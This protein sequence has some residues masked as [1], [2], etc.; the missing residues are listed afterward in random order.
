VPSRDGPGDSG[1]R[2][3]GLGRA[4]R[5]SSA[6]QWF[7]FP[8]PA[9][10]GGGVALTRSPPVQTRAAC[11]DL[12]LEPSLLQVLLTHIGPGRAGPW[13]CESGGSTGGG[14]AGDSGVVGR[15]V[16]VEALRRRPP[17]QRA[18]HRRPELFTVR[19]VS[20]AGR[21]ELVG[22]GARARS[23]QLLR[24]GGPGR[25]AEGWVE[26]EGVGDEV[27]AEPRKG[28]LSERRG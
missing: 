2:G 21:E 6:W 3:L 8:L 10:G 9:A 7:K 23:P 26:T 4:T 20:L 14:E 27:T 25:R 22:S 16:A 5:Q 13:I 24:R 12:A 19:L 11:R 1:C 17:R 28:W 18:R 15:E